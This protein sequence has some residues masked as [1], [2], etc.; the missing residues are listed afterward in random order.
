MNLKLLNQQSLML[1]HQ[2]LM[3]KMKMETVRMRILKLVMTDEEQQ[4]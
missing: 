4:R 2:S 1:N 3:W